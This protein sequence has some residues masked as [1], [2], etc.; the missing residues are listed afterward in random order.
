M[1]SCKCITY[2]RVEY[3]NE[4]LNCFLK[5]EYEDKELIIV[6]D[7]EHQRLVFDHPQVR[8]FNFDTMFP[9][10]G[11]KENFAIKQCKGD[12]IALWDDDDIALP[13]H[14]DNISNYIN[15][16]DIV[17]WAEGYYAE[18]FK[19]LKTG[20]MQ[21][22]GMA[23]TKKAWHIAQGVPP[24][25][26]GYDDVFISNMLR[27]GAQRIHAHPEQLS[28]IYM[29]GNGTYHMSGM[30]TDTP[31]RPSILVRHRNHIERLREQG[32]IP[33]GNVYLEPQWRL[34]YI[35]QAHSFKP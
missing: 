25:N 26:A 28:F 32:M 10:I 21:I 31:S 27:S 12:I 23:Y 33:T 4:A 29:W 34:D 11:D 3:L 6:N 17:Q 9:S 15:G 18:N 14:L 5:Q 1:I 19:I 7:Y 13:N 24:L 22:A 2:G 30:G 20:D 35:E 16:Y 8:I